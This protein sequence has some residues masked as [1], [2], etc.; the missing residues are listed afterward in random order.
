MID[1]QM[2]SFILLTESLG[3]E[4]VADEPIAET[5]VEETISPSTAMI[6]DLEETCFTL[7]AFMETAHSEDF[8]MGVE[9]GMHRAAE[10]IENVIR[11][12]TQGD[13]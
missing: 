5:I 1:E 9:T 4:V 13:N 12:H 8:A 7:R 6:H 10:M 3:V 11:R 2:R